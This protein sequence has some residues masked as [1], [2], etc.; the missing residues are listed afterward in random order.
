M[1]NIFFPPHQV[2]SSWDK[3]EFMP[4][5]LMIHFNVSVF[6]K[7]FRFTAIFIR[8]LLFCDSYLKLI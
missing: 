3:D 4:V 5:Y 8:H 7:S 2:N 6:I 1:I